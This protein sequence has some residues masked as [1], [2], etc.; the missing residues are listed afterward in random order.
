[1]SGTKVGTR[2]KVWLI[3]D[4][5]NEFTTNNVALT[6]VSKVDGVLVKSQIEATERSSIKNSENNLARQVFV[7][8]QKC[9]HGQVH[10][11][12]LYFFI[13]HEL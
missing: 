6:T 5:N 11:Y 12:L 4:W 8:L 7:G 2:T 13:S 10:N 9:L 1:M 3:L